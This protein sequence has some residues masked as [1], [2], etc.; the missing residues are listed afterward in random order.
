MLRPSYQIS[1]GT[2][3]VSDSQWGPLRSLHIRR[4]K[5]GCADEAIVRLSTAMPVDFA[6]GDAAA[7]ELGWD[8][9]TSAVF[10]G[11]VDR[12]SRG[13][14]HLEASCSGAQMKLM[15]SRTDQ[16][17]VSQNAG[18]VVT[19]LAGTA[20][21]PTDTVEDGIDL[22]I[23][24][25]DSARNL[26]AHCFGLSRLCGF[27]L[28]TTA[29]GSLVFSSFSTTSADHTFRYGADIL[30]V[31]IERTVPLDGVTVVPESP[32]SSAGD[33]TASWLV[34]DSSAHEGTSGSGADTLLLS[35]PLL[36]TRDAAESAAKARL[37]FSQ[38][39]SVTGELELA[40][41]PDVD[42]GETVQLDGVPGDDIDG[43]YQV[44]GVTH[45][46]D[47]RRGFRTTVYLGGMP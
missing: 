27:D 22:P 23:Y 43:L 25:A 9:A 1:L 40:G 24:F 2:A 14:T 34:K 37:Y 26:Y 8:G 39:D 28:F 12:I 32:A 38:R 21:V 6:E 18:Q 11:T 47:S 35:D 17:F 4:D 19:A 13:I 45:W 3:T 44:M 15:R 41:A 36:R 33:E 30:S 31:N 16:V 20:G 42:L 5:R 46:L 29:A 10:T 7:I